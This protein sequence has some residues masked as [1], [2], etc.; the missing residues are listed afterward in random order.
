MFVL[1]IIY[2]Q[3]KLTDRKVSRDELLTVNGEEANDAGGETVPE[4]VPN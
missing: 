2:A 4:S 3:V 1:G